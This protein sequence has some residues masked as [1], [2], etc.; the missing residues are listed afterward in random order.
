MSEDDGKNPG[1]SQPADTTP[2]DTQPKD[3]PVRPPAPEPSKDRYLL[4]NAEDP[5]RNTQVL[6]EVIQKKAKE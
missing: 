3:P 2:A 4:T 6:T 1:N 5:P